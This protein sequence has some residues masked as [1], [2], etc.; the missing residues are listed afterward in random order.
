MD[1]ELAQE[2]KDKLLVHPTG[3]AKTKVT[4][5]RFGLTFP[6]RDH[7]ESTDLT[8]HRSLANFVIKEGT[9]YRMKLQYKVE[10]GIALGL[11]IQTAITRLS[12]FTTTMTHS[13]GSCGPNQPSR[14]FHEYVG[15]LEEAP[16]GIFARGHYTATTK[17]LDSEKTCL[18]EWEWSYDVVKE[19]E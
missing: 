11:E 13:I 16:Q 3:N 6:N 9:E 19:W 2:G 1:D 5:L 7:D 14:P 18:A 4:V 8:G 17:L 12:I 10:G 15:R